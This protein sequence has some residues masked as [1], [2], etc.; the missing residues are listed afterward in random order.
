MKSPTTSPEMT[1]QFRYTVIGPLVSRSLAFGELR[2]LIAEQAA[3]VWIR[4]DGTTDTVHVRTIY[5]WLQQYRQDGLTALTLQV[6][7]D[8]GTSAVD[9][10]IRPGSRPTGRGSPSQRPS[11]FDLVRMGGRSA[12][13]HRRL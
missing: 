5:R 4:P 11:N 2:A 8:Q 6:R 12:P 9:P 1:A 10:A 7:Q 3:R 13:R